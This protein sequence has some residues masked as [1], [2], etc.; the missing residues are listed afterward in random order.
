MN[1]FNYICNI[2]NSRWQTLPGT[3]NLLQKISFIQE[4]KLNEKEVKMPILEKELDMEVFSG[5]PDDNQNREQNPD[6]KI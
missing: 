1:N 3:R 2:K 4:W 5:L 6:K